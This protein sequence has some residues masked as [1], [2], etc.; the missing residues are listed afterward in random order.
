MENQLK[1]LKKCLGEGDNLSKYYAIKNEL[2]SIYDHITESIRIRSKCDWYEHSE[3]STKFFLNLEKQR[4]AQN[5]IKKL[6]VDDK[7]IIDQ[8]YILEYIREFY[9]N[10]FKKC[11]QKTGAEIENFLRQFNIPKLPEN[12]SKLCEEDLTEKDLYDSLKN[13]QNNKSPG[14]TSLTILIWKNLCFTNSVQKFIEIQGWLL[15]TFFLCLTNQLSFFNSIV[16]Q[17]SGKRD[18]SNRQ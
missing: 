16:A 17:M 15:L 9:E 10:L 12:K 13:M 6:I 11:K 8:T 18:S 3:K 14:N 7:K 5:T 2:D 4:R 1:I